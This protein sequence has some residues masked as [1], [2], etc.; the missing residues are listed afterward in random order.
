[1]ENPEILIGLD[2]SIASREVIEILMKMPQTLMFLIEIARAN[3]SRHD[4]LELLFIIRYS[5]SGKNFH[6]RYSSTTGQT[7]CENRK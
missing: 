6:F 3:L 2:L 4:I 5:R 7:C 1:M